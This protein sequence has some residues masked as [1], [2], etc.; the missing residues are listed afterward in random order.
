MM[1]KIPSNNQSKTMV[2]F[3][4]H[5]LIDF[6]T[7]CLIDILLNFHLILIEFS[8]DLC[9]LACVFQCCID[10]FADRTGRTCMEQK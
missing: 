2:I 8:F 1:E 3:F 10:V 5:F 6:F 4:H 7:V 9:G